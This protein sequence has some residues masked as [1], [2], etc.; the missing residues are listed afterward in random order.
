MKFNHEYENQFGFKNKTSSNRLDIQKHFISA[1]ESILKYFFLKID[2]ISIKYVTENKPIYISF[3]IQNSDIN[4]YHFKVYPAFLKLLNEKNLCSKSI[5]LHEL[6]HCLDFRSLQKSNKLYHIN[7]QDKINKIPTEHISTYY[8]FLNFLNTIRN[9]GTSLLIECIITNKKKLITNSK[10]LRFLETDINSFLRISS[11]QNTKNR[12][13]KTDYFFI[14]NKLQKNIYKYSDIITYV[15]VSLKT[16]SKNHINNFNNFIEFGSIDEK[17]KFINEILETD[18]SEWIQGLFKLI[19]QT[20][21]NLIMDLHQICNLYSNINIEN[22]ASQIESLNKIPLYAYKGDKENVILML[23]KLNTK[24]LSIEEIITYK[25]T[26]NTIVFNED[27]ETYIS[28]YLNKILEI[29]NNENSHIIDLTISYLIIESDLIND[30]TLFLGKQDD[31][32][33]LESI[34]I[35]LS[36]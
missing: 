9:E 33:I 30:E 14:L 15:I 7:L 13:L 4:N 36:Y 3:D 18:I 11:K 10:A 1:H 20:E 16:T 35:L 21:E 31:L 19:F 25:T 32:I 28:D 2:K 22:Q 12:M 5:V 24:K 23:E 27:I 6:I 29:R 8:A 34:F 17:S 26:R